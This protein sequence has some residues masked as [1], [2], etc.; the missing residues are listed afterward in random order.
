ME[1]IPVDML[2]LSTDEK[3]LDYQKDLPPL[4]IPE[5]NKTLSRYLESGKK[6]LNSLQRCLVK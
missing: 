1:D 2:M 3:L 4:P 5:L 6:N